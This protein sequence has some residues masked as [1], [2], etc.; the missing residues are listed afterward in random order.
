MREQ[1]RVLALDI[2]EKRTGVAL[3]DESRILASPLCVVEMRPGSPEWKA[4]LRSIVEENEPVQIVIGMPLNQDG[5]EGPQAQ[6]M[7]KHIAA[8]REVVTTPVIEWDERY[9]TVQAETLLIDADVSRKKR[10]KV[11]DKIAASFIL[12]GYLDSLEKKNY[13]E[14]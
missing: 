6:R 11:I 12:Q 9:T 4:R 7:K 13:D 3:S 14:E 1:G 2:G 5:E 8:L 10:K